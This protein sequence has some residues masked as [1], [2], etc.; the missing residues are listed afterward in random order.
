MAL[1]REDSQDNCKL[2]TL[3]RK[4][5][6]YTNF[7]CNLKCSYCVTKS[8]PTSP[9]RALG[10]AN[11]RQLVDEA[12]SLGFC[13]LFFT[14]GEPFTLDDIYEMLAYSSARIITTVLTNGTLLSGK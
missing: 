7:D 10:L 4:L 6:V 5:W 13:D 1:D 12:V 8:T 11:V 2:F 14:G 3:S 9:R